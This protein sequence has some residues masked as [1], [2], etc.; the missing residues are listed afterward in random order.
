MFGKERKGGFA[1]GIMKAIAKTCN[2]RLTLATI[3]IANYF[4]SLR[5]I[6]LFQQ[7]GNSES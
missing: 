2:K 7:L 4:V 3:N 1:K 5:N 6:L